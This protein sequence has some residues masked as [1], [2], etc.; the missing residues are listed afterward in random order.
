PFNVYG[1]GQSRRFL[2]P[3]I[4]DQVR[5]GR[6]IRVMDLAPK[7]DYLYIDDLVELLVATMASRDKPYRV[8]N[9]GS[10]QSHSV[11]DVID[12]V[13]EVANTRLAVVEEQQPRQEELDDVRADITAARE[14]LGWVPQTS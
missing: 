12:T 4:V 5:V 1:P 13:Q 6:Q 10:G 14:A 9:A 11:K 8:M 3:T 7:R 2:I